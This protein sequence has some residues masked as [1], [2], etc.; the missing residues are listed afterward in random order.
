[1]IVIVFN[2]ANSDNYWDCVKNRNFIKEKKVFSLI[3]IFVLFENPVFLI[4]SFCPDEV[5]DFSTHLC[6]QLISED[7]HL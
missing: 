3:H 1:M 5:T 7:F 6:F 2:S 4:P